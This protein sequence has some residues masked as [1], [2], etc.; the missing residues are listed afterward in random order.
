MSS[1]LKPTVV[2]AFLSHSKKVIQGLGNLNCI[3]ALLYETMGRQWGITANTFADKIPASTDV[4]VFT[5]TEIVPAMVCL[6]ILA[7]IVVALFATRASAKCPVGT[8][9]GLS[10]SDCF[11]YSL[12]PLSW[13]RAE[14]ECVRLGGH[15]SS[16]HSGFANAFFSDLPNIESTASYWIGGS[17]GVDS[18]TTW[19]WT[20]GS[21]FS[22]TNWASGRRRITTE[23]DAIPYFF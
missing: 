15:L 2:L 9:Q 12:S 10:A 22:Y 7:T 1:V 5:C 11:Y 20:D 13:L 14:E 16:V 17:M 4:G 21:S 23:F 19:T 8:V 18:F 3:Q 6:S